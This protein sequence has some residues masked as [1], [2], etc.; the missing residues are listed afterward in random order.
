MKQ[1]K[2]ACVGMNAISKSKEGEL[3][4]GMPIKVIRKAELNTEGRLNG[5][6]L[7]AEDRWS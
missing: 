4:V 7:R 2:G 5:K 1:V 6:Y 3:K